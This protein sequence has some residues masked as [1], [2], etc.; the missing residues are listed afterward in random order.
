MTPTASATD[1]VFT[2]PDTLWTTPSL[3]SVF[4]YGAATGWSLAN[5]NASGLTSSLNAGLRSVT[6]LDQRSFSPFAI[7]SNSSPLPVTLLYFEGQALQHRNQ[8][9]WR[10]ASEQN[11]RGFHVERSHDGRSFQSIGFMASGAAAGNSN[12]R[13]D[14]AFADS[15]FSGM[16]QHYRLRQEDLDGHS[17]YSKVITLLRDAATP[18]MTLYPNPARVNTE[19]RITSVAAQPVVLMLLDASGTELR[20]TSVAAQ[21]VVLMLLDAS[22]KCVWK[23]NRSIG[24]GISVEVLNLEGL[25]A[26]VYGVHLYSASGGLLGVAR[27]V[28]E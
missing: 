15:S 22:G 20:I 3:V 1:L 2:Y 14:Y 12:L 6:L 19:L 13:L 10:T 28:K 17:R 5:S 7:G 4:H 24:A 27:L 9:Q 25:S 11:N 18:S 21:P 8:L 23:R 26:G 16:R